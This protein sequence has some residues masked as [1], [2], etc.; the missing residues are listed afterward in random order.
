MVLDL[1]NIVISI[2][3][4]S[5]SGESKQILPELWSA[6]AEFN[7]LVKSHR[8]WRDLQILLGGCCEGVDDTG[9]HLNGEGNSGRSSL[10]LQLLV[11]VQERTS[12]TGLFRTMKLA[13]F[14]QHMQTKQKLATKQT[15]KIAT[16][17]LTLNLRLLHQ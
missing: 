4:S 15:I 2:L 13:P 1:R 9:C 16:K 8:F 14:L 5:T 3:F 10:T 17:K 12:S 6:M 11:T 7:L